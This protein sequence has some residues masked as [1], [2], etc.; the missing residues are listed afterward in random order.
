LDRITEGR[1]TAADLKL[2]AY[3]PM[4]TCRMGKDPRSSVVDE[5][6]RAH[7]LPGLV[8]T[9]ASVLPGS[10]YVNPQITIMALA[11]RSARRLATELT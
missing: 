7:D 4:G 1:W 3:H 8:V 5:H 11:T 10:T 9:D 6:G 2:S